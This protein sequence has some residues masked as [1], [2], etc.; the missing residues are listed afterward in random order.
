LA[1]E[2]AALVIHRLLDCGLSTTKDGAG[3]LCCTVRADTAR[4][5]FVALSPS[6][7]G[8]SGGVHHCSPA[9]VLVHV[10]PD[11]LAPALVSCFL[12]RSCNVGLSLG[13]E[14]T[15]AARAGMQLQPAGTRFAAVEELL[16]HCWAAH[17]HR[18]GGGANFE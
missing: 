3:T 10:L 5:A 17:W 16:L 11:G 14:V 13:C 15:Q 7:I 2:K 4:V 1:A 8:L 6:S 12:R 18:I 9:S